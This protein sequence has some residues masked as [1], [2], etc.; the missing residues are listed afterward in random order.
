MC[1]VQLL[2]LEPETEY[3]YEI[4][5]N[6][7]TYNDNGE[8][9]TLVTAEIGVGYPY[10]VYGRVVDE[11]GIPLAKTLVYVE[12]RRSENRSAPLLA[13]TDDRGYWNVN[14]GNLK[15]GEGLVYKWSAGDEI[16]VTVVHQ[17][18]S[19]TFRTLV[20]GESP[21]NVV[22]VDDPAATASKKEVS[23]V[24]LPK[25][26]ALGQN[27]PNP[28]NPSTT[29]AFDIPEAR[30]EGVNVELNVYNIRGQ[31]VRALVNEVKKPGHYAVQWNGHNEKGEVA[32]S[33]VYFYRIKA[34]DYVATRKMVL[35][36]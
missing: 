4:V 18:A 12:A 22:K 34:G 15:T 36:K 3:I 32:S 7:V 33:G 14:L 29:I 13:I 21:Q 24:S 2:N 16:R 8:P 6:G 28:F 25:A 26:F 30:E 17:D 5:S 20:S 1:M 10:T 31:L 23:R 19:L 27:F 11:Q 35:L 9:F